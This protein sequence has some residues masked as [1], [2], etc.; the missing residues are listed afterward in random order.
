MNA[1]L[2]TLVVPNR[3]SDCRE[4]APR[5]FYGASELAALAGWIPETRIQSSEIEAQLSGVDAAKGLD[6]AARTGVFERRTAGKTHNVIDMSLLACGRAFEAAQGIGPADIDLIVYCGISRFYVE[7]ATASVLHAHLKLER[8]AAF[9]ISDACLGFIDGWFVADAMIAA[10]RANTALIVA[11]ETLSRFSDLSV[12]A[13]KEGAGLAQHLASLTLGDGAAAAII[14]RRTQA[15]RG[16]HVGLRETHSEHHHL[17]IIRDDRQPMLSQSNRLLGAG[18][19]HFSSAADAVLQATGWQSADLDLAVPHQASAATIESGR[20]R[21]GLPADRVASTLERFG[22]MA[23]V[24]VPFALADAIEQ[25]R[26]GSGSRV[27]LAG[28]G[29]GLGIGMMSLTL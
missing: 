4:R 14:T 18:L 17:C 27:L 2:R 7:P 6:I 11:A 3:A 26:V 29:S 10:G 12:T 16:L 9:D 24:A 22:N 21:L 25:G 5:I 13:V 19:G 28:F 8:A 23:S 20:R 1:P 15:G